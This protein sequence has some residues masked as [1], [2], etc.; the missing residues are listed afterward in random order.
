MAL[1]GQ[2]V[3]I[4]RDGNKIAI[5]TTDSAVGTSVD[6]YEWSGTD[7]VLFGSKITLS[8][9]DLST[10]DSKWCEMSGDGNNVLMYNHV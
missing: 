1:K 2:C 4:S 5:G 3:S 10:I 9:W 8:W 6:V 7:W